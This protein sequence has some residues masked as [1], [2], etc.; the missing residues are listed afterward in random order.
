MGE[1]CSKRR[2]GTDDS[3]MRQGF[4]VRDD[5]ELKSRGRLERVCPIEAAALPDLSGMNEAL[6]IADAAQDGQRG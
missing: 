5:A 4:S 1:A 2:N 3:A 6:R